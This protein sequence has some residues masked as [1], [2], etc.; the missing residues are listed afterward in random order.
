MSANLRAENPTPLYEQVMQRILSNIDEGVYGPGDRLPNEAELCEEYGVS[1]ITLR[2]AVEE[3][4]KKGVLEK[5]QGKGTFVAALSEN[6]RL[7][8]IQSFHESQKRQ[9]KKSTTKVL[10]AGSVR[11]SARD[12]AELRL[13]PGQN[14]IETIRVRYV[15]DIPVVLEINHFSMAYS[16][17]TEYDL[18][19][20]L[21][22]IL[23]GFGVEPTKASHEVSLTMADSSTAQRLSVPKDTPLVLLQEVVYDQKGRPLHTS[24]QF[25]RGDIFTFKI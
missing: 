7:K 10:K 11:A 1:R 19:G 16:Y 4:S 24:K 14:V 21:Y 5:H 18:D 12:T 25:I 20:S 6:I 2:R 22:N 9:G 13:A 23:R 17:L 3:L 15:E 8:E